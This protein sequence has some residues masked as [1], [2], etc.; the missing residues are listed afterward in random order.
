MGEAAGAFIAF[1]AGN[2]RMYG[3]ARAER[4][5]SDF[6]PAGDNDTG[7]LV[8][9]DA[10]QADVE[11]IA[12]NIVQV[13]CANCGRKSAD[14][15]FA[16]SWSWNGQLAKGEFADGPHLQCSHGGGERHAVV[17]SAGLGKPSNFSVSR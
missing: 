8:T 2:D 4:N 15:N 6:G 5:I 3:H 17:F 14:E 12:S 13:G 10:G 16:G 1:A 7:G 11:G 9:E